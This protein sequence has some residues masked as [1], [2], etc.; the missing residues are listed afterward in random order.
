MEPTS[1]IGIQR[2]K[3]KTKSP[4]IASKYLFLQTKHD[5]LKVSGE[6][7][8][9]TRKLWNN[10]EYGWIFEPKETIKRTPLEL[11]EI[12]RTELGVALKDNG[13]PTAGERFYHNMA[14]ICKKYSGDPRKTTNGLTA[15]EAR[16]NLM[17]FQ[18]I[19]EGIANLIITQFSER[20][21][22]P[23]TDFENM[24]FKIDTHKGRLP[25]QLGAIDPFEIQNL[26]MNYL[27]KVAGGLY[28]K[29]NKR[30]LREDPDLEP[31]LLDSLV[32]IVG[33]KG[34][35]KNNREWCLRSCPLEEL[36]KGRV[37]KDEERGIVKIYCSDGEYLDARKK[38]DQPQRYF[39]GF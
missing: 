37:L 27:E 10:Q 35:A 21:L 29:V 26:H 6:L 39:K 33:S 30:L 16:G 4:L 7:M 15:E 14:L 18:G 31:W 28:E 20:Q 19:G 24:P 3:T 9:K 17:E 1:R 8:E 13:G 22:G 34:C 23:I 12:L 2:D 5:R 11:G 38:K 36:C 25:I 32:W